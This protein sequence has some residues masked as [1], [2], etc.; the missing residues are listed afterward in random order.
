MYLT[1]APHFRRVNLLAIICL[2]CQKKRKCIDAQ[3]NSGVLGIVDDRPTRENVFLAQ[4]Q[5]VQERAKSELLLL[6]LLS[7]DYLD[8]AAYT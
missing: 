4:E 2:S 5:L 3:R 6:L 1:T 7:A 8:R